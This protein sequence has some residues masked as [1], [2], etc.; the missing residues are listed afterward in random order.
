M[1][2]ELEKKCFRILMDLFISF[3][4]LC[5]AMEFAKSDKKNNFCGHLKNSL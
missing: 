3:E 2:T 1:L 5:F 4:Q